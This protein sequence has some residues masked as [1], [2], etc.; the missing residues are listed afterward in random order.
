MSSRRAT[1]TST[2][3]PADLVIDHTTILLT[4]GL[5]VEATAIARQAL[6]DRV[7][8]PSKRAEIL[9]AAARAALAAGDP[10]GAEDAAEA[11]MRLF[12]RQDRPR[13]AHRAQL[14]TVQ[15]RYLALQPELVRE[16]DRESPG[17]GS[18]ARRRRQGRTLLRRSGVVVAHL[19]ADRDPELAVALVLHGRIAHEL[20]QDVVALQSFE[21]AS[22]SRHT[23]SGLSRAAGW[24]A[25][26]LLAD[27]RHD[28][29]ALLHA[30]RRG[31]DAVDE[32]R[33]LMGDLELR[34][35]AS[36][37][38]NELATLAFRSKAAEGDGRGMLWWIERWRATGLNA[39][40]VRPS[41][42]E[43]LQRDIAALRNVTHR[44]DSMADTD[45]N[46]SILRNER[47]RRESAV[48]DTFRRRRADELLWRRFDLPRLTETLGDRLLIELIQ[49]EDRLYSIGVR[50]GRVWR[51][52]VVSS[53]EAAREAQFARFAL[54]RAAFG[55]VP[56]LAGVGRRLHA[57]LF[58]D[59]HDLEDS[60]QIVV[61]PPSSLLTAP[62]ALTPLLAERTFTVSPS[63]T[64]WADASARERGTG[65]IALVTGPDLSTGEAEVTALSPL[66]EEAHAIAGEHAT[67]ARAL[68]LLDGA[69]LAHIAAH[70]TFRADAPLFSSLRLADGPLTVHDLEQLDTPP[71]AL[72][73]SACD[74]GGA[75]PI[76]ANEALGL[77]TSLLA[78]GTSS[79]VASV[80]PVNDRATVEVMRR[81]HEVAGQGR[82]L[83]EG[84]REARRQAADDG[85]LT[86][87]AAA[88][89]AWGA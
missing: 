54:R 44:L 83:A 88:F 46:A 53:R 47:S 57:A 9:L 11:A 2:W 31:L 50:S 38:G 20:G 36:N 78:M 42:D 18:P 61:V 23:G 26:A 55:R 12:T 48:R 39:T 66:H 69:R 24:L 22:A 45:P 43:V 35:L 27:L 86:A 51:R 10:H 60:D 33:A 14:L 4:A 71:G 29:R 32:H 64:L 77:V 25:A 3:S 89:T 87:T 63:A 84:M 49:D 70:G 8:Q 52:P 5:T 17:A 19:S 37:H 65:R 58:G 72:V 7:W 73:L 40:P 1:G 82:P 75:A 6:V 81:L 16:E 79:A 30:C 21:H 34:A 74:A 67:V 15:A 56:D 85:L 80:V 28:R 62:W 41:V 13:W 76:T 59:A 68:A